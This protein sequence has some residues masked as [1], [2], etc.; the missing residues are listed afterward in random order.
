MFLLPDCFA[1]NGFYLKMGIFLLHLFE[2]CSI[3][4]EIL[5]KDRE[6]FQWICAV[7]IQI[8]EICTLQVEIQ[9]NFANKYFAKMARTKT[10]PTP[11]SM[12]QWN[13][14]NNYEQVHHLFP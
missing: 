2:F 11:F 9:N 8:S 5:Q 7:P 6:A 1:D 4:F 12:Y 13:N 14:P 10:T 3:L